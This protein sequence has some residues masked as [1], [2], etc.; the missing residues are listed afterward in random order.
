[1]QIA[2]TYDVVEKAF[3][4][5]LPEAPDTVRWSPYDNIDPHDW[6]NKSKWNL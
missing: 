6:I 2:H 5:T 1:M 3:H 4:S